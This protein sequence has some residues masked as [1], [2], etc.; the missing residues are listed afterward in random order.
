MLQAVPQAVIVPLGPVPTKVV[1]N[2]T[3]LGLI[4]S[5]R[6]LAGLPHPSGANVERIQYFLG[7]KAAGALS[8]KTDPRRLDAARTSLQA[9]VV[10]LR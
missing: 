10:A 2:L 6:V 7:R 4:A 8:S 1:E 3:R 5:Q 9:A